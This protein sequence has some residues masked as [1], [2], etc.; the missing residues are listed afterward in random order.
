VGKARLVIT[1]AMLAAAVAGCAS[2]GSTPNAA[3]PHTAQGQKSYKDGFKIGEAISLTNETAGQMQANC[4]ASARQ[5]MPG[6]D[7]KSEWMDGCVAGII[8]AEITSG[9]SG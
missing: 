8:Q 7:I 9:N 4:T 3:A 1:G 2:H 5:K 6:A